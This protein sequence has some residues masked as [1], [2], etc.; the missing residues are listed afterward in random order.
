MYYD[1][2]VSTIHRDWKKV[3]ILDMTLFPVGEKSTNAMRDELSPE[4]C[5]FC[6]ASR[7]PVV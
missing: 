3:L 6:N 4:R 1:A 2:D 7:R 5:A